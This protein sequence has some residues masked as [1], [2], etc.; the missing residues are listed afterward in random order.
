MRTEPTKLRHELESVVLKC[1]H[2]EIGD[3]KS[4]ENCYLL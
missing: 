2:V 3:N 1:A 4:M